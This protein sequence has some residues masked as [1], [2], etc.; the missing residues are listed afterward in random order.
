MHWIWNNSEYKFNDTIGPVCCALYLR[1][2]PSQFYCLL[3]TYLNYYF[4]SNSKTNATNDTREFSALK[5]NVGFTIF[6]EQRL[7]CHCTPVLYTNIIPIPAQL[8]SRKVC[9]YWQALNILTFSWPLGGSCGRVCAQSCTTSEGEG[10]LGGLVKVGRI[11]LQSSQW[12]RL[13][14]EHIC[15]WA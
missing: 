1:F 8:T 12:G 10:N 9:L 2:F 13:L 15:T 6:R 7:H 11:H 3:V 5:T 14:K 4:Y